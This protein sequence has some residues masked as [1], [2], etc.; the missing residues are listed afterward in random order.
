MI[1]IIIII[2]ILNRLNVS[3]SQTKYCIAKENYWHFYYINLLYLL[4]PQYRVDMSWFYEILNIWYELH[5]L[6]YTYKI[7]GIIVY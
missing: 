1:I 6:I 2:K 3:E 7:V 4:P 5:I